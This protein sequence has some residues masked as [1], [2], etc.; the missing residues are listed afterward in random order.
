MGDT[1]TRDEVR[2]AYEAAMGVAVAV[3]RSKQRAVDYVQ[4]AFESFLSG[5]RPWVRS[6]G[7]FDKHMMGAVRSI[8]S[9]ARVARREERDS[10]AHATF[11]EN[12]GNEAA[13]AEERNLRQAED[14]ERDAGVV[15]EL[16]ALEASLGD[17]EDARAVLQCRRASE[18]PLKAAEIAQRT[19]I[20]VGRVY[21]A[22]ELIREHL[23]KLRARRE[24]D[25][26]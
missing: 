6:K 3:T 16:G 25:D 22:N 15:D 17:N 20:P 18:E 2:A 12:V 8:I 13:S 19:G 26:E 11:Q 9:N 5:A 10:K 14:E 24:T 23:Q 21:R 4:A 1:P 7:P